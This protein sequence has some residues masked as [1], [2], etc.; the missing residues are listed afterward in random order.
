MLIEVS[1]DQVPLPHIIQAF[2][3]CLIESDQK[4][5]EGR[6]VRAKGTITDFLRVLKQILVQKFGQSEISSIFPTNTFQEIRQFINECVLNGGLARNGLR[7]RNWVG[8]AVLYEIGMRAWSLQLQEPIMPWDNFIQF[9]MAVV[10]QSATCL[11]VGEIFASCGHAGK[12]MTWGDVYLHLQKD[13]RRDW[14]AAPPTMEDLQ[15]I[16]TI[17]FMKG[18]K[19]VV[20]LYLDLLTFA[21]LILDF[22]T[23]KRK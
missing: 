13:K 4:D 7:K 2:I 18:H 8:V 6:P 23:I 19:Y 15:A 10:L 3:R 21:N 16:I 22:Y 9:W 20:L 12:Y 14:V 5:P 11:R 1:P 17:R